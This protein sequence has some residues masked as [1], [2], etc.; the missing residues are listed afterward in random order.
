MQQ[1]PHRLYLTRAT[2]ALA[3][4]AHPAA[5]SADSRNVGAN[6]HTN[7]DLQGRYACMGAGMRVT[8]GAPADDCA[9]AASFRFDGAGG[10]RADLTARCTRDGM[11]F[12]ME[13]RSGFFAYSVYPDGS[14]RVSRVNSTDLTDAAEG[15]LL[16]Q[17]RMLAL[18]GTPDP[19]GA[20]Y[21]NTLCIKR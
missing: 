4:V 7:A 19:A 17:G 12:R 1:S 2:M 11:T 8:P 5:M 3:L 14:S 21:A 13:T 18:D 9:L 6:S 20:G 16:A 15:R 10:G